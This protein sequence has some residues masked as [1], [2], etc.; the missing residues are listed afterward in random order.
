MGG[1]RSYKSGTEKALFQLSKGTCYYPGCG[2]PVL[3]FLDPATPVVNVHICH[4]RGALPGSQRYESKMTDSERASFSNLILLCKPH[5]DL[6]DRV[7]PDQHPPE[8]LAEW[9]DAREGDAAAALSV[10]QLGNDVALSELIESIVNRVLLRMPPLKYIDPAPVIERTRARHLVG[11][12]W[13]TAEVDAFLMTEKSGYFVLEAEAG[14]GKTAFLAHIVER[15]GYVH[16]FAEQARGV[17]GFDLSLESL[18]A[19]LLGKDDGYAA[20]VATDLARG[21]RGPAVLTELLS[22]SARE[23]HRHQGHPIVLVL[24]GLDEAAAPPGE[25]VLALP[26]VLPEGVFCI[27]STRPTP[28]ALSVEPPLRWFHIKPTDERNLADV[29]AYL[30]AVAENEIGERTLARAGYS[31]DEFASLLQGKSEG[32]WI[33]LRYAVSDLRRQEGRLDLEALPQGLWHY[34]AR[35]WQQWRARGERWDDTYLP[36]LAALAAAKEDLTLDNWFTFAGVRR[37]PKSERIAA[38][39]WRPF[40]TVRKTP[41]RK[42]GAYHSTLREFLGGSPGKGTSSTSE[43]AL[44]HEL[45]AASH[46]AHGRIADLCMS[47]LGVAADPGGPEAFDDAILDYGLR[48]AAAHLLDAHRYSDLMHLVT[49]EAWYLA[50]QRAATTRNYVNDLLMAWELADEA[51]RREIGEG[52]AADSIGL[53]IR[54]AFIRSCINASSEQVPASLLAA[55]VRTKVWTA[56]E[57]LTYASAVPREDQRAEALVALAPSLPEAQG[58]AIANAGRTISDSFLRAKVLSAAAARARGPMQTSLQRDTLSEIARTERGYQRRELLQ[59]LAPLLPAELMGLALETASSLP[60]EDHRGSAISTIAPHLDAAL[61]ETALDAALSSFADGRDEALAALAPILGE[62]LMSR[63]LASVGQ[64]RS[65]EEQAERLSLLAS[66]MSEEQAEEAFVLACGLEEGVFEDLFATFANPG[67]R[68]RAVRA[69]A[70]RLAR[71]ARTRVASHAR[72]IED[73]R[74]RAEALAALAAR[75]PGAEEGRL[76][77]EAVEAIESIAPL[78]AWQEAVAQI[79][80]GLPDNL[81]LPLFERAVEIVWDVGPGNLRAELLGALAKHLPRGLVEKLLDRLNERGDDRDRAAVVTTLAQH[82]PQQ[83]LEPARHIENSTLRA[84]ALTSLAPWLDSPAIVSAL[85][86]LLLELRVGR[87]LLDPIEAVAEGAT[88]LPESI[89]E[90]AL[91]TTLAPQYSYSRDK[92]LRALARVLSRDAMYRGVRKVAALEQER[93]REYALAVLLPW[94]DDAALEI[95]LDAVRSLEADSRKR[96]LGTLRRELPPHLEEEFLS[97]ASSLDTDAWRETISSM[98]PHLSREGVID[99]LSRSRMA[100]RDDYDTAALAETIAELSRFIPRSLRAAA[101]ERART[102]ARRIERPEH[103]IRSL[104]ELI[105]RLESPAREEAARDVVS[106]VS[107]IEDEHAAARILREVV[108][109]DPDSLLEASLEVARNLRDPYAR[110][111]AL[112]AVAPSLPQPSRWEVLEQAVQQGRTLKVDVQRA[113]ALSTAALMFSNPRREELLLDAMDAAVQLSV[114]LRLEI[115]EELLPHLPDGT[116]QNVA[117]DALNAVWELEDDDK[118][119]HIM[120]LAPW[121]DPPLVAE[122][123]TGMSEF[124]WD[125]LNPALEALVPRAEGTQL[126]QIVSLGRRLESPWERAEVLLSVAD[127][128][129]PPQ[130][131]A[132]LNEVAAAARS[133]SERASPAEIWKVRRWATQLPEAERETLLLEK[134]R[135]SSKP[136][137]RATLLLDL[138]RDF[139]SSRDELIVGAVEAAREIDNPDVR[140]ETFNS[141]AR[142]LPKSYRDEMFHEL[143]RYAKCSPR[144]ALRTAMARGTSSKEELLEVW[145][146]ALRGM[147]L[148]TR[149]SFLRHVSSVGS[150]ISYLGGRRGAAA[151]LKS[152]EEVAEW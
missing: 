58:G 139:P 21:D 113:S 84:R 97:L 15:R 73:S 46:T 70:P 47:A 141:L 80:P 152:I 120:K 20:S 129:G 85:A 76:A 3:V 19:Q 111:Q 24:D 71:S 138:A 39:K 98:A 34:Y 67:P 75:F 87:G 103:R 4:I 2:E 133:A 51:C 33:Y 17:T 44:R 107:Q 146:H 6:V 93:E 79:A 40:L 123:L 82:V 49:S 108:V 77:S 92:A 106:L 52:L 57:A 36:L 66:G 18:A 23:A 135:N 127:R 134:A 43:Q 68:I 109:V 7:K 53:Q 126:L 5:H 128:L 61:L 27:A 100:R 48:Y 114:Y 37:D 45:A 74:F 150:L 124:R 69:I 136:E 102:V 22:R 25:N 12:E 151:T 31:V 8:L 143:I 28:I 10:V 132:L 55:L 115:L 91:E 50:H 29:R 63:A 72:R 78:Y 26:S 13:L 38:E 110:V 30:T 32:L 119:M 117:Q 116:R 64:V 147:A 95:G 144:P 148:G 122:V 59:A 140:G 1:P 86:D 16:L 99:A 104:R 137:H 130:E 112:M 62:S 121:L 131:K 81:S 90:L 89:L 41:T 142:I 101:S 60:P 35:Y 125:Y 96:V 145:C 94:A 149:Q 105:P 118:S 9:K 54:C 88:H 65:P 14:M 83:L 11:R 56:D 42:Y